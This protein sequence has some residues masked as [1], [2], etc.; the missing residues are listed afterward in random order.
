MSRWSH[1]SVAAP[2][3]LAVLVVTAC[4]H[5]PRI[6]K[7]PP[8]QTAI[9][10]ERFREPIE[11]QVQPLLDAELIAGVVIGLYDVGKT[12][13]YGF[14]KGPGQRPPDGNTLFELG[15]VTNIYTALLL[16]DAVQRR[17][18]ELD[19]PVSELLPLGVT[20]PIRDK[21]AITLKH[22]ALHTS[23]LP[24]QPPSVAARGPVPDPYAGYGENALYND[25]IHTELTAAPGTQLGYS[26]F[27]AGLLGFALGRKLGGDG[28][29]ARA[30]DTRVLRPLELADTFT[31]VPAA[32]AARR[33]Q[34]TTDDLAAAPPWTYD[35]MAGAGAVV[36]SAH[37]LLRLIDVELDAAAGSTQPLRR[38]MKLTQEPQIDRPGDNVGLGWLI[39]SAGRYWRNGGT[40]GFHLYV[41]FDPKIRR[42]VVVLA[43]TATSVIDRLP[44]AMFKI[45]EGTVP[46]VTRL[47]G[48][49]ELAAFTGNYDL[50][51]T[52]LQVVLEGKRLY[53][54]GPGE[55]RHRLAPLSDHEF[56]LEALGSVAAFE[57]DGG[58][59]ARVVFGVGDH[60][61]AASRVESR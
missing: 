28:G 10:V 31:A 43:A 29:Y 18:V 49:A 57:K 47:P 14:G 34:G 46:P 35:A 7:P 5:P 22:L 27:G 4:G 1:I 36:S 23:G 21:V 37:D 16:A 3:A 59:V 60:Q 32:A 53:L 45:L 55:P 24:R 50:G 51:G 12:E 40:G 26:P 8:S 41:G 2:T 25:L 48:P 9:D 30:L 44:D 56:W 11:A 33:A 19:T 13:I 17:E 54:A 38:A 39:D 42:G 61:I 6:G 20:V 58:K 52:A 15:P